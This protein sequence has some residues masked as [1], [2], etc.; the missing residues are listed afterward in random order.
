MTETGSMPRERRTRTLAWML[1]AGLV[2]RLIVCGFLYSDQTSPDRDHWT[3]AYE[4]GRV[5]RSIAL[6]EGISNPLFGRTGPTA[7]VPPVFP[8]ILAGVF[9]VFGIYT[10]AS[11][12]AIL[13]IDSLF[14]ALTCIPVFLIAQRCFGN[15]S[16]QWAGW[17][18]VFF[19]YGIYFSADWV[20][21]TCLITLLLTWLFLAALKLPEA[22]SV[23]KWGGFGLGCGV[24]ALTE[25][26]VLSVLPP[27]G[28]WACWRL[29]RQRE[30][31]VGRAAIASVAFLVVVTPWVVRNYETF[32]RFIPMRSGF[33][34]ELY[35]GNNGFSA[36]WV[37][38]SLYPA[39]SDAEMA[40][41][42]QVGEIAYMRHKVDQAS[43]FIRTHP[44]FFAWMFFRRNIYLWTGFWSFS[45]VY[46]QEEPLDPANVL[47]CTTLTILA[48]LGLVRAFRN[49]N[50]SAVPFLI[51][52][53]LYPLVYCVTHPEV[54]YRR[55]IDPLFVI[56][57]GFAVASWLERRARKQIA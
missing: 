35:V 30:R 38:R 34:L 23:L 9:K 46:L 10:T 31:W 19:P 8:F 27:L 50:L 3:F 49:D 39:H 6:G 12:L 36:H 48:L 52:L 33:G 14:S 56:L 25:P 37:N 43:A 53:F 17:G 16:A 24:A 22:R 47:V 45:P 13:A 28:L 44:G 42:Q 26:S 54:Y 18:W 5:A 7:L 40:E 32:H 21:P 41:F 1:L 29:Y 11:A 15:R 51:V 4:N 55:P 57:A 20:W 2:V